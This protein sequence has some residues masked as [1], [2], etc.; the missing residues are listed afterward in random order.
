M[1]VADKD[2][3]SEST[4]QVEEAE[5]GQ[6]HQLADDPGPAG[7]RL[8]HRLT[9]RSCQLLPPRSTRPPAA[10]RRPSLPL[11]EGLRPGSYPVRLL[12]RSTKRLRRTFRS[13]QL[14]ALSTFHAANILTEKLSRFVLDYRPDCV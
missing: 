2:L 7:L 9:A 8:G 6:R 3:V 12:H 13:G 11:P 4:D 14:P 5:P 10:A 1:F